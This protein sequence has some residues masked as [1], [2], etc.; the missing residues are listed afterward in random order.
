MKTLKVAVI[1]QGRSGRLLHTSYLSTDDR[2]EIAAVVDVMKKR[3]DTAAADY[4]CDVYRDY[5][6]LL[7]RDDLD[8][9]VN[10]SYSH[11]HTPINLEVLRAGHN[12]L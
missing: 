11:L 3:R 6:R 4:G 10:A 1:G 8:L 5:R 12:L 9:V 7:E 2:F